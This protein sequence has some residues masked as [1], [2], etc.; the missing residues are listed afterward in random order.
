M[1]RKGCKTKRCKGTE[2][3]SFMGVAQWFNMFERVGKFY[4][5]SEVLCLKTKSVSYKFSV[6]N[7]QICLLSKQLT[8]PFL[9]TKA[10]LNSRG[11]KLHIYDVWHIL[12]NLNVFY[13]IHVFSE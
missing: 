6:K 9:Y 10:S 8:K 11:F 2:I 5:V 4:Q 1:P 13:S 12:F 7:I 3:V